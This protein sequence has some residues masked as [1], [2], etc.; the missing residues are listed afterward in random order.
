MLILFSACIL[1]NVDLGVHLR[2]PHLRNQAKGLQLYV[3]FMPEVGASRGIHVGFFT[4]KRGAKKILLSPIR[5]KT[6]WM[7]Q[8]H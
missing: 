5:K 1:H 3:H 6:F 2:V 8:V 7:V 4:G